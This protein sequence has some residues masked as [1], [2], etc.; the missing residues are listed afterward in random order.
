MVQ[1]LVVQVVVGCLV[2]W[3]Y[4]TGDAGGQESEE[5]ERQTFA[6]AKRHRRLGDGVPDS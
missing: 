1:V 4:G 2:W 3:V 6:L 5:E